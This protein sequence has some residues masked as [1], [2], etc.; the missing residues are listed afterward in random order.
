MRDAISHRIAYLTEDRKRD[1]LALGLSVGVNIML[2]SYGQ[3]SDKW[4]IIKEALC[5]TQSE[6]LRRKL[7]IKTPHLEQPAKLLSGGNQQKIIIAKWLTC[8]ADIFIFDEPTRGIDVGAKREIYELM[9]TLTELGKSIIMISS[10]LPEILGMCDRILVMRQGQITQALSKAEA[11]QEK[12]LKYATLEMGV[13][14]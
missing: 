14:L 1:G 6:S 7:K 3:Y 2:S 9:H 11:T 5:Q 8:D 10:E 4:G 13:T 12:I